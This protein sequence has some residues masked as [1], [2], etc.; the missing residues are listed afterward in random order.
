MNSKALQ[1]LVAPKSQR[2]WDKAVVWVRGRQPLAIYPDDMKFGFQ[3]GTNEEVFEMASEDSVDPFYNPQLD[4]PQPKVC[5]HTIAVQVE[6]I[7]CVDYVRYPKIV[8]APGGG[9][10]II[11]SNFGQA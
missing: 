9:S 5:T 3:E 2:D 10:K 6:D 7:I 11:T 8:T 4:G 1:R